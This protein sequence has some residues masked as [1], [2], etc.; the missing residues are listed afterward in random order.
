MTNRITFM[1]IKEKYHFK[2]CM[3]IYFSGECIAVAYGNINGSISINVKTILPEK[4][5][6]TSNCAW[7]W[8]CLPKTFSSFDAVKDYIS[9]HRAEWKTH[10]RSVLDEID[11]FNEEKRGKSK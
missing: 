2:E 3:N 1:M 10:F 7:Y 6:E 8:K 4:K 9:N 5:R 11:R